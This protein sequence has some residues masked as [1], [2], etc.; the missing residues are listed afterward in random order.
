MEIRQLRCF[1]KAAEYLSFTKAARYVCIAESSLSV[2]IKQLETELG[3][4]LFSRERKQIELTE[5]GE[6]LL[7]Y[8][9]LVIS[10]VQ[11]VSMVIQ[12]INEMRGGSLRI[13]GIFSLCSLL[14]DTLV[15]FRKS[16]LSLK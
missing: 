13:G 7:P 14:T 9:K 11:D 16:I 6:K 4:I 12:D 8:A 5:A 3:V 15:C 1:V 10:N 2:Q